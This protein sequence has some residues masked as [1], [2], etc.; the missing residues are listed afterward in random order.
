MKGYLVVLITAPQDKGQEL[1][2]FI[3][4]SKLGACVNLVSEV[5]SIYWWKGN[6]EKDKECLLIVK[7]S[8]E[9]FGRLL[10]EVKSR[11]PYTV[12]EIIA[13]PIIAGNED[14]LKW[15]EESLL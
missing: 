11:H 12:P 5:D 14:Y 15:I 13:L 8:A 4:N 3:I 2:D 10:E 1:A 9:R 7:T 6:V